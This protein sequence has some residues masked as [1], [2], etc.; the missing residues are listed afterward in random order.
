MSGQN[1]VEE[2]KN[3]VKEL[4]SERCDEKTDDLKDNSD[5]VFFLSLLIAYKVRD[6]TNPEITQERRARTMLFS[7][8]IWI[9]AFS[10]RFSADKRT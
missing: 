2:I 9:S 6:P 1:C 3:E 5:H 10:K 4:F 8:N 7:H